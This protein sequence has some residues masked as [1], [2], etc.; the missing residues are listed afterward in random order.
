MDDRNPVTDGDR[1][2]PGAGSG[3]VRSVRRA[4]DILNL[5]GEDRPVVT[6]REIID[7]TGLAK[8]TVL[9]LVQTRTVT[10]CFPPWVAR[11]SAS[12]PVKP[13]S[14]TWL[15]IVVLLLARVGPGGLAVLAAITRPSR[16][17]L[18]RRG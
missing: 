15:S 11:T 6:L 12:A 16:A 17:G 5:L 9:R 8:T 13:I 10:T 2:Q 3:G 14:W 7:A 18:Q 4:L 1:E